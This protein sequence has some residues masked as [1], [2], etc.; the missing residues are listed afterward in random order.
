MNLAVF[1]CAVVLFASNYECKSLDKK[2]GKNISL[3]YPTCISMD[4]N[5]GDILLYISNWQRI[6]LNTYVKLQFL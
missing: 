2:E 5:P 6:N 1:L 4:S 3:I